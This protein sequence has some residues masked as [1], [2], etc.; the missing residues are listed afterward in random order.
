MAA[1]FWNRVQQHLTDSTQG[2]VRTLSIWTM[3]LP[4]RI[5]RKHLAGN[6]DH[7]REIYVHAVETIV[8]LDPLL[9]EPH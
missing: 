7:Q 9:D 4:I 2:R 5:A 6:S 1:C 3:S 8:N